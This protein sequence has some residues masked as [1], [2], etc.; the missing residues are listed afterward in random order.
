MDGTTALI[1]LAVIFVTSLIVGFSGALAPGPVLTYVIAESARQG[2]SVGPRVVLGHVSLEV[3]LVVAVALGIGAWLT[4]APATIAIGLIGGLMLLWLARQI[5][6]GVASGRLRL[7]LAQE[8]T[9]RASGRPVAAGVILSASNP[10]FVLWWAT[11][12]LGYIA[13]ALRFGPLG[14]AVFY[15]GHA[16]ADLTWYSGVSGVVAAGRRYVNQTL[17]RG[18]LGICGLFLIGLGVF[19]LADALIRLAGLV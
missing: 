16:L 3:A 17:Y 8:Q 2:F 5:L 4:T 1:D 15:A 11:I 12:G 6:R 19:F 10:Y 18:V 14:L 7:D 9:L 13:T